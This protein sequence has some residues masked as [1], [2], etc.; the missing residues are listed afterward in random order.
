[1]SNKSNEN[2]ELISFF[3]YNEEMINSEQ[4]ALGL[5]AGR[6]T[7]KAVSE[8]AEIS[9]NAIGNMLRPKPRN[10]PNKSTVRAV[11]DII[12]REMDKHGY[13]F[14]FGG[15]VRKDALDL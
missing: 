2:V 3:V 6:L 14:K 9:E 12:S 13:V 15:V 10:R 8:E 4:I 5:K 7:A 1:M 11:M